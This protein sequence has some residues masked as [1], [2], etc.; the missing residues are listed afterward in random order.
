MNY[1]NICLEKIHEDTVF[2]FDDIYWSAEMTKAWN[3]IKANPKVVVTID[4]FQ[5][6]LV[7]FKKTQE[8][9]DFMLKF[10]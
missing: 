6:G 4:L 1:F 8:K 9:Q 5:I 3:E 2:I 7:F 10:A